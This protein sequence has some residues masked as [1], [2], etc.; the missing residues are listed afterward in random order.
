MATSRQK[1]QVLA[2]THF[3]SNISAKQFVSIYTITNDTQ[4][5][6]VCLFVYEVR[7]QKVKIPS[8]TQTSSTPIIITV[9]A[10]VLLH[11]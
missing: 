2:V 1:K 6:H 8:M 11:R 10:P 3:M 9:S 4:Y 5:R 7:K